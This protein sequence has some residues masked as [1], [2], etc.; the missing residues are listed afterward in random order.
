MT[1]LF[2]SNE[3]C[4]KSGI[5]PTALPNLSM[6]L[7]MSACFTSLSVNTKLIPELLLLL[8]LLSFSDNSIF[9]SSSLIDPVLS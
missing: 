6:S 9:H 4:S 1:H 8:K 5:T 7:V 2:I 3:F